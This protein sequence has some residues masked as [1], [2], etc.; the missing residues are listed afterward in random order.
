MH[1]T[2]TEEDMLQVIPGPL[3]VSEPPA[4]SFSP[5]QVAE[6]YH[7]PK[8]WNGLTLTGRGEI[9][10]VLAFGATMPWNDINGYFGR[11]GTAPEILT[12]RLPS[13][14]GPPPLDADADEELAMSV[15]L[16]GTIAPEAKIIVYLLDNNDQAWFDALS[17]IAGDPDHDLSVLSITWGDFE[18]SFSDLAR[19][20]LEGYFEQI[21]Q[22]TT[23]LVATGDDGA[24]DG[25]PDGQPHVDYPASSRWVIACGGTRL[26]ASPNQIYSEEVWNEAQGAT[27]G[28]V[29]E[30]VEVPSWQKTFPVPESLGGRKGRGLPDITGMA[31]PGYSLLIGGHWTSHSRGTSAVAPMFAGLIAL[32]NQALG[33]RTAFLTSRLYGPLASTLTPITVGTNGY[34]VA[35]A[36]EWNACAGLGRPDGEK[37]LRALSVAGT[38]PKGVSPAAAPPNVSGD[39]GPPGL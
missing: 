23:I 35:S 25:V 37:L 18:E 12:V 17:T 22:R 15:E 33:S 36:G 5:D 32:I 4:D 1:G 28:G 11:I 27:G 26:N 3:E 34:W 7:F 31:S 30:L 8:A 16:I 2:G 6:L 14:G 39:S 9:V 21:A 19:E 24:T 13:G 38:A 29:S 10:G 20:T